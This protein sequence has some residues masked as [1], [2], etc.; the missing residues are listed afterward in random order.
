[1]FQFIKNV[2]SLS[3]NNTKNQKKNDTAKSPKAKDFKVSPILEDNKEH[4]KT[5]FSSCS[6]I[7]I[8]ELKI[9]NNPAFSAMIVYFNNMIE[10]SVIEE[11]II[12]KLTTKYEGPSFKPNSEEYCKYLLGIREEDIFEDMDKITNMILNGR[13]ALFVDGL[14]NSMTLSVTKPPG[15]NIEEP[16]VESV[17]R[18]PREGFTESIS[19]NI[20]LLR[21]R[22]KSSNLKT[23]SLIIGHQTRTDVAMAYMNNIVNQKIVNE[24]RERLNKI[25]I[26][27]VTGANTLKEYI[28]DAPLLGFPTTFSSERPDTVTSK[29]LEG[30]IAVLVDGTPIVFT[31]PVI[32]L[33]FLGTNEDFYLPFIPATINRWVRYISF[34]LTLTLPA[35]YIAIT[36]FHQELIPTPLLITIVKS[37]SGVPYPAILECILMLLAFEI[38]REA[39]TRMPRTVGQAISVVGALVLGQ[40]AVEAGLVS[41]PMVIVV[42]IT[43]ISGYAVPSIDMALALAFPRFVLI[44]LSGFLGLLGVTCGLIIL[45]LMLISIRS[46]GVPYMIGVAPHIK[47][48]IPLIAVRLPI[49]TRFK[50]PWFI[51]WRESNR[52]K[53]VSH[54]KSMDRGKKRN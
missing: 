21:K 19:T 14:Y 52:S 53:Q 45:Y 51:T 24:L 29:I 18:G 50:R 12:K 40:A 2:L 46:F 28:E 49:W 41:T 4:I 39:G 37:R 1:M 3:E 9:T 32:F 38:L 42:A 26:D 23:E 43:A 35:A 25:D 5:I 11:N 10:S 47:G 31:L 16:S 22:I 44:L 8:R 33:E 30:R 54:I 6:D 27:A 13:L 17:I 36:S 7:I 15:R 34:M 20:V 48:A